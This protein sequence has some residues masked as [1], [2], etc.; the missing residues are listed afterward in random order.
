MHNA[1]VVY[2]AVYTFRLVLSLFFSH[3]PQIK[4]KIRASPHLHTNNTFEKVLTVPLLV[5]H[6]IFIILCHFKV[7]K[8]DRNIVSTI[9]NKNYKLIMVHCMCVPDSGST[10]GIHSIDFP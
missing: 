5:A 1:Y 9:A 10:N 8:G 2:A 7:K 6:R 3:I 4:W